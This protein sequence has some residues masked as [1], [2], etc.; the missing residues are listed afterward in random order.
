MHWLNLWRVAQTSSFYESQNRHQLLIEIPGITSREWNSY[1]SKDGF[2]IETVMSRSADSIVHYAILWFNF[3][4]FRT[5]RFSVNK[6]LA[7]RYLPGG[8]RTVIGPWDIDWLVQ[9]RRNSSALAMELRLS[10]LNPSICPPSSW[11]RLWLADLYISWGIPHV[12]CILDSRGNYNRFS[13]ATD[14]PM[15]GLTLIKAVGFLGFSGRS[16]TKW[17]YLGTFYRPVKM[18]MFEVFFFLLKALTSSSIY[19]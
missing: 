16:R 18:H 8:W 4:N 11:H 17:T 1:I 2:C 15:H 5:P 14:N 3:Q 6:L 7:T 19:G 9:E 10:C 12:Q 13:K